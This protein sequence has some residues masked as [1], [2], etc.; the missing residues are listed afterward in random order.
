[1]SI[2]ALLFALTASLVL[3]G[4]GAGERISNLNQIG[5]AHV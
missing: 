3:T 2:R 5:R 4:C 1:M